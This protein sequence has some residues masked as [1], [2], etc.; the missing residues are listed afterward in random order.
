MSPL[1]NFDLVIMKR[2]KGGDL[3]RV[4]GSDESIAF[5]RLSW[6]RFGGDVINCLLQGF[7]QKIFI[8]RGNVI[9]IP[10]ENKNNSMGV[11]SS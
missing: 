11:L 4:F 6:L 5:H 2:W 8:G 10:A 9:I 7:L 1:L 3:F